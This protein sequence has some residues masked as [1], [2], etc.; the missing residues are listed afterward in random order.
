[1]KNAVKMNLAKR[2]PVP[3][4]I[5][6]GKDI[7]E[8]VSGA[9]YVD[10][11]DLFREY[12]QNSTDSI[13]QSDNNSSQGIH[14]HLDPSN[15]QITIKDNGA[16][17][18]NKDFIS[19]M[20]AIGGSR[21]RV[22]P[23]SRGFRGV[24]RLSGLGYCRTLSFSSKAKNDKKIYKITWDCVKFKRILR[25][26]SYSGNLNEVIKEVSE[27]SSFPALDSESFFEVNLD[28]I[29]RLK[30][31][32]LLNFE[33][34]RNY[35]AQVA[36]LPFHPEFKF[37][38]ELQAWLSSWNIG[39]GY[40]VSL[41]DSDIEATRATPVYRPHVNQFKGA[42]SQPDEISSIKF[43]E[44]PGIDGNIAAVGWIA[45]TNYFG[46]IPP[47]ELVN[48]IRFRSGNIQIGSSNL[49]AIEFPE[50]RFNSWSIG[51][52]H[53]I[54]K[55]LIP[56]G[57]RDNFEENTHFDNLIS[58]IQPQLKEI[59]Q[60][61]RKKSSKRQWITKFK[62]KAN[63]IDQEITLLES[64]SISKRK[65][66][67]RISNIEVEI[68]ELE[69]QVSSSNH[70]WVKELASDINPLRKRVVRL[71]SKQEEGEATT[72]LDFVP[73]QKQLVYQEVFELIYEVSQN[74]VAGNILIEKLIKKLR[75]QNVH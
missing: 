40:N 68:A 6:I 64:G 28:G 54:S 35:I 74:K 32:V 47:S 4:D 10:P 27:I 23:G 3:D 17:I 70:S 73:Y 20:T 2:L 38:S 34:V 72:P 66:S 5:V 26:S 51:E 7:L 33:A 36:P 24:G 30:N 21:K 75:E 58:Q 14:I 44:L 62:A 67:Q 48:G 60:I 19:T 18:P 22:I 43:F 25:D 15:R 55:N 71:R 16:G 31:D 56:N 50:P 69:E 49:L 41:S 65:T 29:I 52:I 63:L 45:E 37:S 12:I 59:A 46:A 39:S 11:L 1:M 42:S 8:L 53:T 57:R 13:D 9:M 61:C